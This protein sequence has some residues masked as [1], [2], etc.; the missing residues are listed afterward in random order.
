MEKSMDVVGPVERELFEAWIN[1]M[2]DYNVTKKVK[3]ELEGAS[4][5][6]EIKDLKN[7]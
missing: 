2:N 4:I 6:R 3:K 5:P 7:Y 1:N